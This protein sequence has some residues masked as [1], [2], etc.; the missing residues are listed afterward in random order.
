MDLDSAARWIILTGAALV[1]LGGGIWLAARAGLPLGR[2]PGD[3]RWESGPVTCFVPVA[4]MVVLSL[5]LTVLINI[6]LR[7]FNR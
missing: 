5:V 3:F 2:L 1:V 7:L 6:L 4:S